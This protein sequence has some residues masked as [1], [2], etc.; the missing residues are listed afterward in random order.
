MNRPILAIVALALFAIMAS[1]AWVG[2]SS[3]EHPVE[4]SRSAS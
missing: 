3:L 2:L 4:V 1:A